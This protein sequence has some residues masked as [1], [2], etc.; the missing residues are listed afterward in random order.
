MKI[1]HVD[2]IP[3]TGGTVDG[4]WPQGHEPEE[5]LHT[6]VEVHTDEGVTGIGSCFTS[7]SL[8]S[9]AMNL[10]WPLLEKESAVEPERV[11]EKLRQ[12]VLDFESPGGHTSRPQRVS[13]DD[14]EVLRHRFEP[15]L[16]GR[17]RFVARQSLEHHGRVL[18]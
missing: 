10:L 6:L 18:P 17:D 12:F 3:L 14:L 11:T 13:H 1:T 4:G 2:V 7:G 5:D 8:V 16:E 9:G 15:G